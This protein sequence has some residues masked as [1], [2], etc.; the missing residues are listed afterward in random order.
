[1]FDDPRKELEQLQEKLLQDEDWFEKELDSAK[2]MI[3][4]Q[5]EKRRAAAPAVPQKKVKTEARASMDD[6]R[7]WT[8]EMTL[9]EEEFQPEK[10]KGVKGLLILASLETLGILA[11]A[12][13]WALFLL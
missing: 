8:R 1:M 6:T 5:P 4:Q 10:E 7:V 11:V 12:A 2:R 3:G 9:D 13:Y